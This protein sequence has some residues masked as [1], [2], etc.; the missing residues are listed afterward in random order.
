MAIRV[1]LGIVRTENLLVIQN[2][3]EKQKQWDAAISMYVSA[4]VFISITISVALSTGRQ[5]FK[6]LAHVMWRFG[7]N[8]WGK[9]D[10]GGDLGESCSLSPRVLYWQ[11]SLLG[12]GQ[13]FY[14]G[15]SSLDDT[16]PI[17]NSGR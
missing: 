7:K 4:S 9:L 15:I 6:E 1:N 12:E 11:N 5:V 10:G 14:S 2:S 13:S 8:I 3:A 16:P 17:H